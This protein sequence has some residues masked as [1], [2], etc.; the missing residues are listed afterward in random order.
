MNPRKRRRRTAET[1]PEFELLYGAHAVAAALRNP[2]RRCR[3][4]M[5]TANAISRLEELIAR[6]GVPL[7][8]VKPDSIDRRLPPGAVH[9]GLLL[10]TEPLI[11]PAIEDLAA[12]GTL[13]VLDQVTDPHNI[14]AILRSCAALGADGLVIT[15]RHSPSQSGL[16]AKTASGALEHVPLVTVTNLARAIEEIKACG[17]QVIGLD[18]EATDDLAGLAPDPPTALVLGAEGKGLRRLTKEKCDR[19]A[20]IATS[21]PISSLNVSNAAAIALYV[22]GTA[23]R[24]AHRPQ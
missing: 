1:A 10:E 15:E 19:L 14:G 7:E 2:A 5:A 21:G 18:G 13:V 16:I 12:T 6:T 8:K 20:R 24:A 11:Q 4:L 9:Q 3:R 23:S 17:Y 22:C